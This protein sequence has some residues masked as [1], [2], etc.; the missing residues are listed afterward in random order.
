[1]PK[2]IVRAYGWQV[3]WRHSQI[4]DGKWQGVPFRRD[5]GQTIVNANK[6]CDFIEAVGGYIS[7]VDEWIVKGLYLTGLP[8]RGTTHPSTGYSMQALIAAYEAA[9]ANRT[10]RRIKQMRQ[11]QERYFRDWL[12]LSPTKITPDMLNARW[13]DLVR[14]K[15][16]NPPGFGLKESSALAAMM[17]IV[18]VLRFGHEIGRIKTNPV[19]KDL[20]SFRLTDRQRDA[21]AEPLTE[22]EFY[23]ILDLAAKYQGPRAMETRRVECMSPAEILTLSIAIMGDTGMRIGEVLALA[24]EDIDL[25]QGIIHVDNHMVIADRVPETKT[26]VRRNVAMPE[27][28][29]DRLRPYVENGKPRDP[30]F[31][32]RYGDFLQYTSWRE[33]WV[34]FRKQ[35]EAAQ[36]VRSKVVLVP[37]LFRH[38]Y[39][40]WMALI[41]P[42]IVL[43]Q[44]MGHASITTTQRYYKRGS[45]ALEVARAARQAIADA[46][47]T[48][49]RHP[50]AVS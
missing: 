13:A 17:T 23:A 49:G 4:D 30:L 50:R 40:S 10:P 24:L 7:D 26:G 1:M 5:E 22:K 44:A 12:P 14:G 29:A 38:S 25:E 45:G 31:S 39:A 33:Y 3:R 48:H 20:I 21:F 18:P 47:A 8:Y 27:G 6:L 46:H 35:V 34:S 11:R 16:A 32:N 15:D 9:H 41:V 19:R 43:M 28:L 2:P 37:H 42:A 36:I